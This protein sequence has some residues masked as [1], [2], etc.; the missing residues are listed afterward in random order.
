[1][2]LMERHADPAFRAGCE[3]PP[4]AL[5]PPGEQPA[6]PAAAEAEFRA[7][8]EIVRD[9]SSERTDRLEY[10]DDPTGIAAAW[11]QLLAGQY[12]ENAQTAV[13]TIRELTFTSPTEVWFR[14]DIATD[15]VP[16]PNRYGIARRGDDGVWRITRDTLCQDIALAPG[17][18]CDPPAERVLP[19]SAADDP[20]FQPPP[21]MPPGYPTVTTVV[22]D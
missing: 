13:S 20:R 9:F 10:V 12:A 2:D 3:P 1:M 7:S 15:L 17:A 22:L 14:Y 11:D 5:P 19:P 21:D 4:P 6:D 16:F 18:A 8:W